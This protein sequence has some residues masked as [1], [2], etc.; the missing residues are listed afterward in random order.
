MV[1]KLLQVAERGNVGS[2]G[3]T[4]L[5]LSVLGSVDFASLED[6][7]VESLHGLQV[8]EGVGLDALRSSVAF[9]GGAQDG[10]DFGRVDDATQVSVGHPVS[11]ESVTA[12]ELSFFGEGSV[13]GF[14]LFE[15]TL[16]PDAE[17]TQMTTRSQLEQVQSRNAGKFN[18]GNVTESSDNTAVF[19]VND[20]GSTAL[21]VATVAHLTLTSADGVAGLDTFNVSNGSNLTQN[22]ES[23]ASLA[24]TFHGRRDD[25]GEFGNLFDAVTTSHHQTRQSR[26]SQSRNDSEAALVDVDLAMPSAP[27]LGGSEH[28]TT[29]AHVTE[30]TLT[31]ATSTTTTDTGNTGNSATSTPAFSRGLMTGV[32]ADSVS[33]TSV[34]GNVGV[35]EGDQVR[36]NGS[37][38][39]SWELQSG[40]SGRAI[41]VI[42]GDQRARLENEVRLIILL[43]FSNELIDEERLEG[44]LP[45]RNFKV[46]DWGIP[47]N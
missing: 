19:L 9:L 12:L 2:R 24:D 14:E 44:D 15:S 33:L 29:T 21:T 11:R 38:E 25:Q 30:S 34:L 45:F 31:R 37:R 5:G 42:N 26:G 43:H 39:D 46:S 6:V 27:D 41:D 17:T 7:R 10:L 16:S 28:A 35:D 36:A 1:A 13:D 8:L 47:G 22:F 40:L 4:S 20:Q 3:A 32:F 18:T 23:S